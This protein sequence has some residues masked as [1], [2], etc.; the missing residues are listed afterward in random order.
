[1]TAENPFDLPEGYGGTNAAGPGRTSDPAASAPS[2]VDA[3]SSPPPLQPRRKTVAELEAELRVSTSRATPQQPHRASAPLTA[4]PPAPARKPVSLKTL[5]PARRHSDTTSAGAPPPMGPGNPGGPAWLPPPPPSR[6]P[7]R[8]TWIRRGSIAFAALFALTVLW[9]ALTAPLSRSLQPIAPPQITLV[10]A[11]GRPI[12]RKGAVVDD[13]VD[14]TKL[15]PHVAQ[16]FLAIEDRRFYSHWGVDPRGMARALWSNVTTGTTQ[17][18][19]TITQQLAK[20]TFLNADQTITRKA[21]ELLIAWWMEAWLSKDEILSRYLSNA[22]FGDNVYGLRAAS[23]HY[24]YRQPERL[25]L[26]Q[27]TMLAGLVKA[28]SRLAPTRNLALAQ[29]RQRLVIQAMADAGFITPDQARQV[30]PA[31]IDNRARSTLPTG[32]YFA[33]WAMPQARATVRPGYADVR[34][35]TTLDAR[36]QDIA[37]RVTARGDLAGAQV[38]LVAM[39]PNGEVVAMIGGRD[40]RASPFNRATQARRQPGSTFKLIVYLTA[41]RSGMTPDTMVDDSPITEGDY[42]PANYGGRYRGRITLA[43][44]FAHSSNVVTVRLY[45]Q[46]GGAA[47]RRTA[48]DLGIISPLPDNASVALGSSGVTL[49]ELTS[50]YATVAG[51]Y[52]PVHPH[53]LREEEPGLIGRLFDGQ[54]SL[55]GRVHDQMLELLRGTV[56]E[57]TGRAARLA[58]PAYGK[59]GTTQDSRDALFVGFAGNLVVGVWIGKDDNTPIRG[60]TGGGLP[61]RIWR[62]FMARAIPGAAP[63][64]APRPEPEP[65]VPQIFDDIDIPTPTVRI[66]PDTG[67]ALDA[68]VGGVGISVTRDGVTVRPGTG[69]GSQGGGGQQPAGGPP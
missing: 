31:V 12:A 61:A 68:Q 67:P 66:D 58:I 11:D 49:L 55:P 62:D 51:D 29:A 52:G 28:P 63:R 60:L 26:S 39:R 69:T 16:A 53:A 15:P 30:P 50:A 65:A 25:T 34:V 37:R 38:A 46:L 44:A 13:P 42:R 1:M 21:R 24:F 40:Y 48:R 59:T 64:A 56:N 2:P 5:W 45:Q 6:W 27:A 57:G 32:T 41:L 8:W 3:S 14:V 4:A 10:S 33:D 18:G 17:G 22:Y 7:R 47:I 23:M 43:Q 35:T 9:L 20:I 54:S 19:S 36:L